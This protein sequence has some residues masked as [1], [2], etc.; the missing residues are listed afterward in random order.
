MHDKIF[1]FQNK[2]LYFIIICTCIGMLG[3]EPPENTEKV[4]YKTQASEESKNT[5]PNANAGYD[6]TILITEASNVILNGSRS[7]DPDGD[8]LNYLWTSVN[9]EI[10]VDTSQAVTTVVNLPAPGQY[11][12]VLIV[13]D[14]NSY[15]KPDIVKITVVEPDAYANSL[16]TTESGIHYRSVQ[17]AIDS[18]TDD[19]KKK[20]VVVKND[21]QE[22]VNVKQNIHLIGII[23]DNTMPRIESSNN[24]TIINLSKNSIIENI[25]VA[26]LYDQQVECLGLTRSAI[27]VS[28]QGAEIINCVIQDSY[29]DGI[30]VMNDSSAKVKNCTM[31]SINGEG[32]QSDD[33][34]TLSV[35]NSKFINIAGSAIWCNYNK[36]VQLENNLIY[37]TGWNGIDLFRCQESSVKHCTIIEFGSSWNDDLMNIQTGIKITE[38]LSPIELSSNLTVISDK[39]QLCG[40]TLDLAENQTLPTYKYNYIFSKQQQDKNY[41]CE[42]ID[43]YTDPYS[44]YPD[45]TNYPNIIQTETKDPSI[46][47]PEAGNFQLDE[48]SPAR[49]KGENQSN[50]GAEG[51]ILYPSNQK[52]EI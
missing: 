38:G 51:Q 1:F 40:I 21:F 44:N 52:R 45:K 12:F 32:I 5:Q 34:A 41:Y 24:D 26:N 29:C 17:R 10:I 14:N 25:K 39:Q 43:T 9:S 11:H 37:K 20:I 31:N 8:K 23:E 50:P 36:L 35:I 18:V 48:N 6:Q 2:F 15:S 46:V 4:I 33:N 13:D 42:D 28:D 47:S 27:K 49:E 30:F 16:L 22:V 7:N 3:C 19:G